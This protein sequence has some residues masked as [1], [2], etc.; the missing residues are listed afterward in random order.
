MEW[1][2]SIGVI[3]RLRIGLLTFVLHQHRLWQ[4]LPM[5]PS[6]LFA[7]HRSSPSTGILMENKCDHLITQPHLRQCYKYVNWDFLSMDYNCRWISFRWITCWWT[8]LLMNFLLIY[9]WWTDLTFVCTAVCKNKNFEM[10]KSMLYRVVFFNCPPP[11]LKVLSVRLHEKCQIKLPASPLGSASGTPLSKHLSAKANSSKYQNQCQWLQS[12]RSF[13]R[14]TLVLS[15]A[16]IKMPA[17]P[18]W[19]VPLM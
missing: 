10:P 7:P 4:Q 6:H 5:N 9:F 8:S 13:F 14:G 19:P 18:W 12:L 15:R 3:I 1:A 2:P 11:P 17:L 16:H